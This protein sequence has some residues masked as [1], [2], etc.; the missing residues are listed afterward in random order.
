M[1]NSEVEL[2]STADFELLHCTLTMDEFH[3]PKDKDGV[4]LRCDPE[5]RKALFFK[6]VRPE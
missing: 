6:K 2:L 4:M 1:K 3:N 5:Q